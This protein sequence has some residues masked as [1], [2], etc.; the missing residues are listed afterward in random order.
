[1]FG[2]STKVIKGLAPHPLPLLG[3]GCQGFVPGVFTGALLGRF[4]HCRPPT[5]GAEA[6]GR[7]AW[8]RFI[9]VL[10]PTVVG[11]LPLPFLSVTVDLTLTDSAGV[12]PVVSVATVNGFAIEGS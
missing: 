9:P 6:L 10:H 11:V 7:G 4:G 8:Q 3:Q 12:A 2:H 1:V 5:V